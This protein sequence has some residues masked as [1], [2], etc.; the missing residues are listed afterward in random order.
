MGLDFNQAKQNFNEFVNTQTSVDNY[1]INQQLKYANQL[2]RYKKR[3]NLWKF[4]LKILLFLIIGAVIGY[5]IF[6]FVCPVLLG[7]FF[8]LLIGVTAKSVNNNSRR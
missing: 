8:F 2:K 7:L 1:H 3:K 5:L 4:L 6:K